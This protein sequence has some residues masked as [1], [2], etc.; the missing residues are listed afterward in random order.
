MTLFSSLSL[1][2]KEHLKYAKIFKGNYNHWTGCLIHIAIVSRS[3]S[4]YAIMRLSEYNTRPTPAIFHV[5][6]FYCAIAT[7]IPIFHLY[8]D[9]AITTLTFNIL[10]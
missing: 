7:T 9:L 2:H 6:F 3:D 4:L 8:I 10:Q 1:T 5:L